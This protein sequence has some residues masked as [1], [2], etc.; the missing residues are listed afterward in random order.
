MSYSWFRGK[1]RGTKNAKCFPCRTPSGRNRRGDWKWETT[2]RIY[3]PRMRRA[4]KKAR[5]RRERYMA[6]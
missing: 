6:P 1:D 3:S 2:Y 5:V 4:I